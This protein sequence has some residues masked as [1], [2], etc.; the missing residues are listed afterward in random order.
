MAAEWSNDIK[1]K[2]YGQSLRTFW[3]DINTELGEMPARDMTA[4]IDSR[5]TKKYTLH[6]K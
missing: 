6:D 2:R 5:M 3:Q 1:D 4:H